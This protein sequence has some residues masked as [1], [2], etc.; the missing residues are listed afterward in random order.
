MEQANLLAPTVLLVIALVSCGMALRMWAIRARCVREPFA[1]GIVIATAALLLSV[2]AGG[3]VQMPW[4]LPLVWLDGPVEEPRVVDY[5]LLL[6]GVLLLYRYAGASYEQWNGLRS[7]RHHRQIG[8]RASMLRDAAAE[9]RRIVRR[10]PVEVHQLVSAYATTPQLETIRT[11]WRD[12]A[13]EILTLRTPSYVIE[14][15]GWHDAQGCWVGVNVKTDDPVLL[16]PAHEP[17]GHDE[18]RRFIAYALKLFP[19]RAASEL[20]LIVAIEEPAASA[21][22]TF[23]PNIRVVTRDALLA[24]LVDFSD[25]RRKILKRVE[26]EPLPDSML[27]LPGVY[28]PSRFRSGEQSL[29]A[30]TYLQEWLADPSQRQMAMLGEYGQGKSTTALM[31]TYKLLRADDWNSGRIPLLIELRGTSPRNLQPLSLLGAWAAQHNMN[32]QALLKLHIAGRIVLIFEGFDEM[33]LVGDADTR[34]KHFK[35]LWQFCYERAKILIT[36]RPNFFLDD[37][38]MRQAL[39]IHVPVIGRPYCDAVRLAPFTPDQIEAAL[40]NQPESVRTGIVTL[41][42][43]NGRFAE[44][45]SRPSL[46]HI[47]SVLW[48]RERLYEKVEQL[49][50]ALVMELFVRHSY[51]R[52]GLKEIDTPDFMALTTA[53]REYFMKG[54]AAFMA[55]N[56]LQNQI[57]V[58][59]LNQLIIDLLEAAPEE[60]SARADAMQR[61]ITQ[62]LRERVRDADQ[63]EHVKTDVRAC[64]L[65]VDD[66]AAPGTFRFGHKSFFEYLFAATVA[67]RILH[68]T[69]VSRALLRATGAKVAAIAALPVALQFLAEIV[70]RGAGRMR[71]EA[72]GSR[73]AEK[74]LALKLLRAITGA[75]GLSW[76]W[77]RYDLC[78][79]AIEKAA[80]RRG[81]LVSALAALSPVVIV[82]GLF[83]VVL[84]PDDAVFS[85]VRWSLLLVLAMAFTFSTFRGLR[86]DPGAAHSVWNL[87]CR[88]LDISDAVLHE[89][90]GTA[91]LPFLRKEPFDYFIEDSAPRETER[92]RKTAKA[93]RAGRTTST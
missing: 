55:A 91:L 19:N 14:S 46:L 33:A 87:L 27:T 12:E 81:R 80:E 56:R 76:L 49:D 88:H 24:D 25:Y 92:P 83:S 45:V 74:E 30:E 84:F 72:A 40:R 31:F 23:D 15:D 43:K 20:E 59:Q 67:E 82:T 38:E 37:G 10:E 9:L 17:P 35:V 21:A 2:I 1:L 39:G 22:S 18:V 68:D 69:A 61:E 63:I 4:Q 16:Y 51:R 93:P 42:G 54:I 8:E 53:E 32:P 89:I 6:F 48:E 34:L 60:L 85:P 90:A 64:G 44:L 71:I 50:S 36:G 58:N 65:L 47:V 7:M 3:R 77:E 29:D 75:K 28:V 5:I 52:Q 41:V 70:Q 11:T 79:G 86:L 13:R 62:P 73:R 66:P 57:G 26:T 78:Q